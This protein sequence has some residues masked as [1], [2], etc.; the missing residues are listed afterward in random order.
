MGAPDQSWWVCFYLG[1]M[2][3]YIIGF[4][5][6]MTEQNVTKPC[7]REYPLF[8]IRTICSLRSFLNNNDIA[9]WIQMQHKVFYNKIKMP[10]NS[11]IDRMVTERD[12]Y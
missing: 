9:H 8:F 7:L 10:K 1:D 2:F 12:K 3:A 6:L 5:D 4:I 11:G